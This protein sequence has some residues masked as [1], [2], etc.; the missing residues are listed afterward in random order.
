MYT[1]A[2]HNERN[3]CIL[4]YIWHYTS[5]NLITLW[6]KQAYQRT[7]RNVTERNLRAALEASTA[8]WRKKTKSKEHGTA[9]LSKGL[10]YAFLKVHC[11]FTWLSDMLMG[12]CWEK[13]SLQDKLSSLPT[14]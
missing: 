5:E 2:V 7:G 6:N 4:G 8:M 9:T 1:T 13:V 12:P 3:K 11:L 14:L 10:S